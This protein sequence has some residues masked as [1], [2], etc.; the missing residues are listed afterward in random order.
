MSTPADRAAG[1]RKLLAH[2]RE[3]YEFE[4]GFVLWDGST[5]P[6][7]LAPDALAVVI[8]DEGAVAALLRH[9]KIDTLINLWVT[10]RIDL[11]NGSILDFFARRPKVR[12]REF[13]R[14]VDKWLALRV[15]AK[16][17]LL[18]R[19]G[20]WPLEGIRGDRARADGS[21]D[22][23]K[24]NVSYHYDVS[25]AFYA[26]FLD[27]E[28]VY[29][30]AY[31]ADWN[32][33]LATAQRDKLDIT[34]R[35]LR[36]APGDRFLDIGCGWGA[37]VCHA[38]QHYGVRAHGVTLAQEQ[39][40]HAREKVARLG[41]ADRVTIEMRDYST[42]Q[43]SYDKIASIGMFEHVGI[44]NYPAY[45]RTINRLL[46]PR[47][48]YLHHAIVRRAKRT[49]KEFH[50]KSAEY[51]ALTRYIFPGGE[52]DH[53]GMS[54]ANLERHGME[55]RDVEGWREHYRR[56]CTLWH[57]RL[58]ANMDAAVREVGAVKARMW[59]AYLAGC[60]IGFDGKSIGIYQT[61]A[62]KRE[63]GLS[64]LPPTRADLYS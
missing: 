48:L 4:P 55:V 53:L 23:N 1:L 10:A 43:G 60:A 9:P 36:L 61:L 63:H 46:R 22:A 59:L 47:G 15:L 45:F 28:M 31:F 64:G 13:R 41:L 3:A 54:I 29:T 16:F 8:A 30:C 26:L 17:L 56:T 11:R 50:K 32:N 27:T 20:P 6:A 39:F 40:D 38:A 2:A 62:V 44:A 42:L 12:T 52:V 51:A 21:E 57:D 49:D 58:L 24:Q 14:R 37:L 35:K 34:C 7:D 33:D 25:N 5:V 18:P 19:G